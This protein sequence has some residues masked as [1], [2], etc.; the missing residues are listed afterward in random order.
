MGKRLITAVS[1]SFFRKDG[2]SF[3]LLVAPFAVVLPSFGMSVHR[4]RL[5]AEP[6]LGVNV[7]VPEEYWHRV[8]AAC[9]IPSWIQR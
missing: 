6:H 7:L 1:F 5:F 2:E 8:A 3:R 4:Q 9:V